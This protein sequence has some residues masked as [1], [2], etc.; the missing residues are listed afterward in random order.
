MKN[1]YETHVLPNLEK[2]KKWAS[3]GATVKEIAEKLDV[4]YSTF[5]KYIDDGESGDKRYSAL[6]AAFVRACAH[7][8]EEVEAALFKS[9]T[10]YTAKVMK[11]VK[12]K[13]TVYNEVGKKIE[14]YEELQA[15]FDEVHVPASVSAQQFWLANRQSERWKY[16]PEVIESDDGEGGVVV[17]APVMD[18]TKPP[19]EGDNA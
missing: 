11:H 8:D 18:A 10:G 15:V 4:A 17:M 16:K 9:A 1:K 13:K 3:E 6:S 7:A 14:E 5:R 2:I 12:V 19:S